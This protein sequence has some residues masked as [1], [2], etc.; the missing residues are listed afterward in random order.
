MIRIY[1][2]NSNER[3]SNNVTYTDNPKLFNLNDWVIVSREDTIDEAQAINPYV[4]LTS[5]APNMK[6][7][8][9]YE[10]IICTK[11]EQVIAL[12][13]KKIKNKMIYLLNNMSAEQIENAKPAIVINTFS[14]EQQ[15]KVNHRNLFIEEGKLGYSLQINRQFYF[16]TYAFFKVKLQNNSAVYI[17]SEIECGELYTNIGVN[18][19]LDITGYEAFD[20]NLIEFNIVDRFNRYVAMANLVLDYDYLEIVAPIQANLKINNLNFRRKAYLAINGVKHLDEFKMTKGSSDKLQ[21]NK[22]SNISL[23]IGETLEKSLT[24]NAQVLLRNYHFEIPQFNTNIKRQ[25]RPKVIDE[26]TK[27][28]IIYDPNDR[29]FVNS[30]NRENAFEVAINKQFTFNEIESFAMNYALQIGV[31]QEKIV[32]IIDETVTDCPDYVYKSNSLNIK[33]SVRHLDRIYNFTNIKITD[34]EAKKTRKILVQVQYDNVNNN[35]E[36]LIPEEYTEKNIFIKTEKDGIYS[37]E[38]IRAT[39]NRVTLHTS[40]FTEV[41]E[42]HGLVDLQIVAMDEDYM[43]ESNTIF[44][45]VDEAEIKIN[46]HV[47]RV[48]V[49]NVIEDKEYVSNELKHVAKQ[50]E[51]ADIHIVKMG[52][53][54][55][56]EEYILANY[57]IVLET[58]DEYALLYPIYLKSLGYDYF[59]YLADKCIYNSDALMVENDINLLNVR[60]NIENTYQL[61]AYEKICYLSFNISEYIDFFKDLSTY[62]IAGVKLGISNV[63]FV[64][65]LSPIIDFDHEYCPWDQANDEVFTEYTQQGKFL[66][67]EL[68]E[69][70]HGKTEENIYELSLQ[71]RIWRN[72]RLLNIGKRQKKVSMIITTYGNEDSIYDTLTYI[73]ERISLVPRDFEILIFDDCSKDNTVGVIN[74]F[75]TTNPHI[76]CHVKVN[77]QNMRYPGYGANS[78][79]KTARG[80][81]AHIVDGDD[82]VVNSIYEILNRG[83]LEEDIISFGH[84]NFDVD[85]NDFVQA[86]YYSFN[87]F[88]DTYPYQ[89][90][91][92]EYKM[93][94]AN[95]THWNKFFKT[96]FLKQNNLYYLENQLVQ[97]SAFL[98]DV[99]YCKPTVQHFSQMGYIYHIGQ[100]SVSS[101]RKGYKLFKDFVNANMKRTPL[102]DSFF[103]QYTY[104][105]KRFM[106]Y[107]EIKD[108]ELEEIVDLLN[109]KYS[110]N[111]RISGIEFF[112]KG[113]LLYKMM[114]NLLKRQ[115]YRRIRQ[116]LKVT[117]ELKESSG[118][119]DSKYYDLFLGINR[120]NVTAHFIVNMKMFFTLFSDEIRQRDEQ[121]FEQFIMYYEAVKPQIEKELISVQKLYADAYELYK[122]PLDYLN[123]HLEPALNAAMSLDL[124]L[125]PFK[126]PKI[127]DQ[128]IKTRE[129]VVIIKNPN[130]FLLNQLLKIDKNMLIYE[131]SGHDEEIIEQL[132]QIYRKHNGE[133]KFMLILEG[134]TEIDFSNLYLIYN[135]L[136]STAY[137]L[138]RLTGDTVDDLFRISNRYLINIARFSEREFSHL[139]IFKDEDMWYDTVSIEHAPGKKVFEHVSIVASGYENIASENIELLNQL[140]HHSEVLRYTDYEERKKANMYLFDYNVEEK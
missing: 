38:A 27:L 87:N 70:L 69:K 122:K 94:Q 22:M 81:Y 99:Y 20:N 51:N 19:P 112:N 132:S 76:N 97:D 77:P 58:I 115:D 36:V 34:I 24:S 64:K 23:G 129:K 118:Y 63:E 62:K 103:P 48:C 28:I 47:G 139:S 124:E 5:Y 3:I 113:Q 59:N 50:F 45:D 119:N 26:T 114:H 65:P 66:N 127:S 78:G 55:E 39:N 15:A 33:N 72:N 31:K 85:R 138:V 21:L 32:Y 107:D 92:Q 41:I 44:L 90:S 137:S 4:Y 84:Y 111:Y 56:F 1:N 120:I 73:V 128:L 108:D 105:M 67:A 9:A 95:V 117:E 133:N 83:D 89:K 140:Y 82:K 131:I 7:D 53:A 10:I 102:V 37:F 80:K 121:V 100:E 98:T 101:S 12:L 91:K 86:K 104:T 49:F 61:F 68:F 96:N 8:E 11:R 134:S 57:G 18:E 16:E 42:Q 116:F 93:L 79:I 13:N 125:E 54:S 6:I 136:Y 123:E 60:V 29:G 52:E 88:K 30:L 110:S 35:Y 46:Y 75:I 40:F 43:Y 106:I 74:Q 71:K 25:K 2:P 126:I 130:K 17:S 109:E 135:T 14:K